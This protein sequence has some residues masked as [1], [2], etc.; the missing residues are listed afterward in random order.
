MRL[1]YSDIRDSKDLTE[2]RW[3]ESLKNAR[4]VSAVEERGERGCIQSRRYMRG[5]NQG[6]MD[7][8]ER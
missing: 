3:M 5:M 4:L 8:Q 6:S 2:E 7:H 1:S